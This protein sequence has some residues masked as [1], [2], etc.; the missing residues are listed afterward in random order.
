MP[1]RSERRKVLRQARR[2]RCKVCRLPLVSVD[3][4]HVLRVR[5][6]AS[7][8][9]KRRGIKKGDELGVYFV[10]RRCHARMARRWEKAQAA[11]KA[12]EAA[13]PWW[14]RWWRR[15]WRRIRRR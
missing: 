2:Q 4:A 1:T 7:N 12:A 8:H 3:P 15:L 9:D 6:T 13:L 11:V 14:R 10:H 5:V